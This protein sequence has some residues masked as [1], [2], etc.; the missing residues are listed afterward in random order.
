MT[1]PGKHLE[2]GGSKNY[3]R[4]AGSDP[5]LDALIKAR[6]KE[7]PQAG[8]LICGSVRE[9][10]IHFSGKAYALVYIRR[11]QQIRCLEIFGLPEDEADLSAYR[12]QVKELFCG[13]AR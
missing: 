3:E 8:Q 5:G 1:A 12:E 4:K 2:F 9:V 13:G 11:G 7:W 6:L 10:T